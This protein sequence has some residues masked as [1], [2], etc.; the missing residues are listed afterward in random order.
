M[1]HLLFRFRHASQGRSRR[2]LGF[3]S[4]PVCIDLD[5]ELEEVPLRGVDGGRADGGP[6]DGAEA[7]NI[8]G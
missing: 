3:P 6:E 2:P 5:L 8:G 1:A 7:G 4:L